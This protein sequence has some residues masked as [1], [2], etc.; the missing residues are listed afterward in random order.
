[1]DKSP[2]ENAIEILGS[3]T[4][5][6]KILGI[7]QAAVWKWLQ[8]SPPMVSEGKAL[9]LAKATGYRITPHQLRPDMY[10]HPADGLP[11][12]MRSAA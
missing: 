1:M 9:P 6:A 3:Q 8:K 2:L 11:E 5:A 4:E 10:P 7:K 12:D